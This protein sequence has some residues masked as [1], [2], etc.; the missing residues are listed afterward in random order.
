MATDIIFC[1]SIL[2]S[3]DLLCRHCSVI[4][5]VFRDILSKSIKVDPKQ[6]MKSK[7]NGVTAN[8]MKDKSTKGKAEER[9]KVQEK[10]TRR[11]R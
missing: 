10:K 7:V 1:P 11:K 2:A 4:K 9:L 5:S 6:K 8:K 3:T